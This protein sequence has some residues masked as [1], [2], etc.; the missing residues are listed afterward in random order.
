MSHT[1]A[2]RLCVDVHKSHMSNVFPVHQKG[3]NDPEMTFEHE[4]E[5]IEAWFPSRFQLLSSRHMDCTNVLGLQWGYYPK[6][7]LLLMYEENRFDSSKIATLW[8]QHN[9]HH[10]TSIY[11]IINFSWFQKHKTCGYKN[12]KLSW[13]FK[14][15]LQKDNQL[16][17]PS[18]YLWDQETCSS[19]KQV[20]MSL[21]NGSS[22]F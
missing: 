20:I 9:C 11:N 19:Y 18:R 16:N 8:Y 7:T 21:T 6:K 10:I 3:K 15:F 13:K 14:L 17:N 12:W 1:L 22:R 4:V 2:V 5:K